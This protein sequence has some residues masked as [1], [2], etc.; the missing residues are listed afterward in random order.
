MFAEGLAAVAPHARACG[1][2]LALEPLHP[3]YAAERGCITTL[4]EM[5]D[6]ADASAT[7]S[8]GIAVDT[9]HVWWDPELAAQLARAGKR[10][11]AH[12]ICDWLVPTGDILTDRGMMGDGVIDFPAIRAKQDA[13]GRGVAGTEPEPSTGNITTRIAG[14]PSLLSVGRPGRDRQD[15]GRV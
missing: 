3:M 9:Y 5:L 6:V 4:K 15:R 11:V 1:V 7:P 14:A 10:I 2:R 13:N 12:H 8:L